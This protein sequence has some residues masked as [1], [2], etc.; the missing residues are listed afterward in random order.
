MCTFS[1]HSLLL[2]AREEPLCVELNPF[3][4][5]A[6]QDSVVIVVAWHFPQLILEYKTWLV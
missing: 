1:A 3:N 6:P 4:Q 2:D 5:A